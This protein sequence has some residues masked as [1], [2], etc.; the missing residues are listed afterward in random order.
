MSKSGI[1]HLII[2]VS[3]ITGFDLFAIIMC[4]P[5]AALL[6]N[7]DPRLHLVVKL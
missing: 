5:I 6:F 2:K 3:V 1:E 7:F 4:N